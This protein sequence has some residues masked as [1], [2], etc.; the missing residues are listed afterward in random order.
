MQ[1]MPHR[2]LATVAAPEVHAW[3]SLVTEH[4]RQGQAAEAVQLYRQMRESAVKADSHVSVAALKA[5]G[6][7]RKICV[8]ARI[9]MPTL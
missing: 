7:A 3:T 9:I 2:V 5:C 1:A 4:S 6:P 8:L